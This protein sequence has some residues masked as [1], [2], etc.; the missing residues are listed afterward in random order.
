MSH[1]W[2]VIRNGREQ[3]PF[4]SQQLK[5]FATEGKIRP[6]DLIRR[7]DKSKSY[8]ASEVKGLFDGPRTE[9]NVTEA[10]ANVSPENHRGLDNDEALGLVIGMVMIGG[11]LIGFAMSFL[12]PGSTVGMVVAGVVVGGAV[13]LLTDNVGRFIVATSSSLVMLWGFGLFGTG[14]VELSDSKMRDFADNPQNYKGKT[15]TLTLEYYGSGIGGWLEDG[16]LSND[17]DIPLRGHGSVKGAYFQFMM[18]AHASR[19]MK[20]PP[21]HSADDVLVTFKC[22]EGRLDDGNKIIKIARP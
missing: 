6:D 15:V 1:Q 4:T 16:K 10:R 3:G 5:S 20:L 19:G 18:S 11:G 22:T 8:P 17:L 21:L 9:A 7:N 14:A 2:F 13:A 12:F